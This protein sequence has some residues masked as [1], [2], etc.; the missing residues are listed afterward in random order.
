[1]RPVN[2]FWQLFMFRLAPGRSGSSGRDRVLHVSRR[3]V[4]EAACGRRARCHILGSTRD[5]GPYRRQW[6]RPRV[7]P[8]ATAICS[9]HRWAPCSAGSSRPQPATGADPGGRDGRHQLVGHLA[10]TITDHHRRPGVHPTDDRGPRGSS[11]VARPRDRGG[12]A[13]DSGRQLDPVLAAP[14]AQQIAATGPRSIIFWA[15]GIAARAVLR[16]QGLGM[17]APPETR[18]R[19]TLQT[20]RPL[21]GV[22]DHLPRSPLPMRRAPSACVTPSSQSNQR[23]CP[24]PV[25][26][27]P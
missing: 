15:K 26:E 18:R 20:R 6:R 1:M 14:G 2:I 25:R 22:T 27:H 4:G 11:G 13:S 16:C 7:V 5:G 19:L 23:C 17:R 12:R 9:A 24:D 10:L 3:P 21:S 8:S